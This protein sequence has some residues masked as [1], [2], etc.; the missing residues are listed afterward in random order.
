[1][2][3]VPWVK[4]E[5]EDERGDLEEMTVEKYPIVERLRSLMGN[6]SRENMR[7]YELLAADAIGRI[8]ELEQTLRDIESHTRAYAG[9]D[10]DWPLA[11]RVHVLAKSTEVL[12]R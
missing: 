6:A 12:K 4:M 2:G 7:D 8:L 5:K 10:E 11:A 1:M 3:R 9:G